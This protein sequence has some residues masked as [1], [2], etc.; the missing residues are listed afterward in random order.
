LADTPKVLEDWLASIGASDVLQTL[1]SVFSE[2]AVFA[3]DSEQNIIYWSPGAQALLGF[4]PEEVLGEH[5]LKANRCYQCMRGCGIQEY[6]RVRDVP[7]KLYRKDGAVTSVRKTGHAFFSEDGSFLG[8]IEVLRTNQDAFGDQREHLLDETEIF[9]HMVTRDPGMKAIFQT[10]KNVAETDATAL[11]RGESGSGKELVARAIHQQ[12]HR[13]EGPFV[14]VNCSA[15]SPALLESELF[16]HAK[17]A[18]TG[19]VQARAGLFERADG[20][21]LLLDEVAELAPDLQAKLLRVLEDQ[22]VVP[23]GSDRA[24]KVNVRV[25]AATHRSLRAQTQSGR[26]RE[27]LMYRLRVV[28][29]YLPPLRERVGDVELLIHHFV[30][31]LNGRKGREVLSVNSESMRA[32]LDHDWPGNVRELKNVLEYAFAVGRGAE[33]VRSELPPELRSSSTP[34]QVAAPSQSTASERDRIRA[35]LKQSEGHLGEAARI[36]NVSRP[37]LWRKRKKYGL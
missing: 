27:D 12:S 3:V 35:A 7:L 1:G 9:H 2:H 16:G 29:I 37:T 34:L 8:G 11:I 18:F 13:A 32:L 26:F 4:A 10:I 6:K 15:L 28:P 25:L 5:C 36:L 19:A 20:G 33:I 21:T 31:Q 24:K 14:A 30:K 17:G 23:V 22:V